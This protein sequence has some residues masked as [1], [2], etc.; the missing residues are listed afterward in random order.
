MIVDGVSKV[1]GLVGD[2]ATA[3]KE[4]ASGIAQVNQGIMQ[5]STVVQTNSATSEETAAASE[6]L[7]SQA[8]LLNDQVSRFKLRESNK[9]REHD[10]NE[11]ISRDVLHMLNHMKDKNQPRSIKNEDK[12][13]G[14]YPEIILSDKEYGKY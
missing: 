11:M 8:D 5:V 4:Q 10:K 6:E 2:I 7:A 3:S 9:T 12:P 1:A 13:D 14:R